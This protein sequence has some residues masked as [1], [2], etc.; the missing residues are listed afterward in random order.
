[1]NHERV[2]LTDELIEALDL[3]TSPVDEEFLPLSDEALGITSIAPEAKAST[4]SR[5]SMLIN[6]VGSSMPL[7]NPEVEIVQTG[8]NIKMEEV[9]SRIVMPEDGVVTKVIRKHKNT[10][11]LIYKNENNETGSLEVSNYIATYEKFGY[12]LNFTDFMNNIMVG[13]YVIKGEVLAESVQVERGI[14]TNTVNLYALAGFFN[15]NSEDSLVGSYSAREKLTSYTFPKFTGTI[16]QDDL[17]INIHGNKDEYKPLPVVGDIIG[18]DKAIMAKRSMTNVSLAPALMNTK[19]LMEFD[20][21]FD[22]VTYGPAGGEVVD[23]EIIEPK[24]AMPNNFPKTM[25]QVNRLL[26]ESRAYNNAI[27]T[28][29]RIGDEVTDSFQKSALKAFKMNSLKKL[30]YKYEKISSIRIV[31]TIKKAELVGIRSKGTGKYGNKGIFCK[32]IPDEDMPMLADGTRAELIYE[33][34]SPH[35]RN[36]SP[37]TTIGGLAMCCRQLRGKIRETFGVDIHTAIHDFSLIEANPELVD[38]AFNKIMEFLNVFGSPTYDHYLGA[39]QSDR[40]DIIYEVVSDEFR[41]TTKPDNESMLIGMA[42]IDAHPE[43]S[44]KRQ[45]I[46]SNMDGDFVSFV[47]EGSFTVQAFMLQNKLGDKTKACAIP[48]ENGYQLPSS[49]TPANKDTRQGNDSP[50]VLFGG[51]ET[52]T[53]PIYCEQE[54]FAHSFDL[55][56]NP[57]SRA[58]AYGTILRAD[59]PSDIKNLVRR[60]LLPYGKDPFTKLVQSVTKSVGY[61]QVYKHG[62]YFENDKLKAEQLD[63]NWKFSLELY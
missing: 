51:T 31:I 40:N 19:A 33:V 48:Y 43:F 36:N 42:L 63:M 26:E 2:T 20:E 62:G 57:D 27:L 50:V 35:S 23:I 7:I 55:A 3:K 61:L 18:E 28:S 10:L 56:K 12:A 17:M 60:D 1:M 15:E 45:K 46:T 8:F 22:R 52:R 38:N 29:Y 4:H 9:S 44:L 24:G 13:T 32:F 41:M 14:E 6:G 49:Q 5:L 37:V 54:G 25:E 16:N 58:Y 59:N 47:D 34:A 53:L 39:N 11:T 21:S 30:L